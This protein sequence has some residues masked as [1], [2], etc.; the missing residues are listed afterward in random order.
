MMLT[1]D[2]LNKTTNG[3]NHTHISKTMTKQLNQDTSALKQKP[4]KHILDVVVLGAVVVEVVGV[5]VVVV[6]VVVG[7]V[8]MTVVG[9]AGVVQGAGHVQ[10]EEPKK[11]QLGVLVHKVESNI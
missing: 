6:G 7:V 9:G 5:V 1:F 11:T 2:W 4:N 3:E 10:H 8:V